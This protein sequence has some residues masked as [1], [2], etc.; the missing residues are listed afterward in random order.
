MA[1]LA[2]LSNIK[3]AEVPVGKL[4]VHEEFPEVIAPII[5]DFL[6]GSLG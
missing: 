6:R 5:L 4:S 3:S 1:A 2:K